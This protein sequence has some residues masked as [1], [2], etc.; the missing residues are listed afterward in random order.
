[1]PAAVSR[2]PTEAFRNP[3]TPGR[4]RKLNGDADA[5]KPNGQ[6]H[7]GE[8]IE[9]AWLDAAHFNKQKNLQNNVHNARLAI[10][11]DP[12]FADLLLYDGM[13]IDALLRRPAPTHE[14]PPAGAYPR[15]L[16]DADVT[17]IQT[18]LQRLGMRHVSRETTMAA[19]ETV[20]LERQF[21]P[22][23]DWLNGLAW[24][25]QPRL[26]MLLP[27]YFGCDNRDPRVHEYLTTIGPMFLMA[28]VARIFRP[29]CKADYMLVLE[30]PQGELKST[31][32]KVLAGGDQWFSDSLPDLHRAD[33]VRV[34]MHLRGLWL[35]EIAEMSAIRAAEASALKAFLTQTE[36]QFIPKFGRKTVREPRQ[37]LFIGTTNKAVYL[38]DETGGRRF[39]PVKCGTIAIEALIR[40]REQLFAE[41]VDRFRRGENWWPDQE[42]EN[43]LIRPQQD[44]RYEADEAWENLI[45]DYL[46]QPYPYDHA[47]ARLLGE[48]DAMRK[49]RTTVLLVA[50]EALHIE[51]PRIATTDQRRITAVLERN[52]WVR[53]ERMEF[54]IPWMRKL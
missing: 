38:R 30:S 18:Q 47:S 8:P 45:T 48:P 35:L 42:T 27:A 17:C 36:E 34:S 11:G 9:A 10:G 13:A 54:G 3:R 40:D 52:G 43:R 5:P 29:G 7:S 6:D 50:R 24:D 32:C 25:E 12:V 46:D 28:M 20:A 44:T 23:R 1:M 22:I 21:H 39:W 53:G 19:I 51:R 26:D 41:A 16:T 37:C 31:A 49:T 14:N 2:S 33:A 4:R 15:P